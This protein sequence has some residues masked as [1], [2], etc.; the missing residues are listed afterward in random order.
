MNLKKKKKRHVFF[1]T[2]MG[3][4]YK[5]IAGVRFKHKKTKERNLKTNA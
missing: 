4:I 3:F 1:L 5:H 2:G